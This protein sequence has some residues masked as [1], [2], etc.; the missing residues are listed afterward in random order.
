MG[1]M[2]ALFGGS[3]QKSQSSSTSNSNSYNESQSS[4]NSGN[5]AFD[6]LMQSLRGQV[7]QG[8]EKPDTSILSSLLG[9]G[10]PSAGTRGFENYKKQGGFD[11]LADRGAGG[12]VANRASAGLLN[13]GGSQ[14]ALAQFGSGLSNQFLSQYLSQL[15]G[16]AQFEGENALRSSD[17][18]LRAADIL[19]GAGQYSTSKADSFGTTSANSVSQ[20]TGT[21]SSQ[22]TGA[23]DFITS[24]FPKG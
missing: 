13:S 19:R 10:D 2:Q 1:I 11:F 23:L 7:G 3:T 6:S 18:S 20:S 9:Y 21:G 24:L 15:L 5:L 17:N 22:N 4:S 8:Y 14:K 16:F 12:I